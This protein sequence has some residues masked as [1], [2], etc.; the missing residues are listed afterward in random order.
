MSPVAQGA[1]AMKTG[2]LAMKT[3]SLAKQG[4]SK[5]YARLKGNGKNGSVDVKPN[6]PSSNSSSPSSDSKE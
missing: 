5:V 4:A 1:M 2:S 6:S 3:G